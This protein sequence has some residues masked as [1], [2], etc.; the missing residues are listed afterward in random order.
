MTDERVG[1]AAEEAARLFA[2]AEQWAR[3][4]AGHLL[5]SDHLAT[6]SAACTVCPVCQ[7]VSVLR[8]VRPEAVEHLLDAAASL[9]AALK[10]AVAPAPGS[11]DPTRRGPGVE[12]I[13]VREGDGE[14]AGWA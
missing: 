12:H 10:V 13:V 5:D 1:S 9:V 2:A 8:G 3:A 11:P 4:H 14:D 6:G 7:G